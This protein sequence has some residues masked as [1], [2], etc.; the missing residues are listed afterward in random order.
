MDSHTEM[1]VAHLRIHLDH[2]D[3]ANQLFKQ[4]LTDFITKPN[5]SDDP[6]RLS[7]YNAIES[8]KSQEP[9]AKCTHRCRMVRNA[10]TTR[11]GRINHTH[12]GACHR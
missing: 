12:R 9:R 5:P 3:T 4:A 8:A 11:Q 2:E 1:I 7:Y 6:T 10:E